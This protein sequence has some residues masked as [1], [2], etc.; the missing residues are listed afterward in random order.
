M[1]L[2]TSLKI[3]LTQQTLQHTMNFEEFSALKSDIRV[4]ADEQLKVLNITK[5][6]KKALTS[7]NIQIHLSFIDAI[8]EEEH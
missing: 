6:S 8:V 1:E 7:T 2:Q 5:F 4:S 3:T